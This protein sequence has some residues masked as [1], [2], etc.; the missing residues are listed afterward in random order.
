MTASSCRPK[1]KWLPQKAVFRTPFREGSSRTVAHDAASKRG[2]RKT[3][4]KTFRSGAIGK[5]GCCVLIRP[6]VRVAPG[7][8]QREPLTEV[9]KPPPVLR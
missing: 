3:F 1:P 8:A 2:V 5:F 6:S 9:S 7:S 4:S